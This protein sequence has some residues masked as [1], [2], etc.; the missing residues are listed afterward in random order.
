MFHSD[1]ESSP[2]LLLKN[3]L[4]DIKTK[5]DPNGKDLK[6]RYL[7]VRTIVVDNTPVIMFVT[8]AFVSELKAQRS[9]GDNHIVHPDLTHI[10]NS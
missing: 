5:E 1:S 8:R 9:I 10:I 2:L 4:N 6:I 3:F 7:L